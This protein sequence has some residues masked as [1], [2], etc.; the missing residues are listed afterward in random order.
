MEICCGAVVAP[1]SAARVGHDALLPFGSALTDALLGDDATEVRWAAKQIS[2]FGRR[3]TSST[4]GMIGKRAVESIMAKRTDEVDEAVL[5]VCLGLQDD[6]DEAT[7]SNILVFLQQMVAASD[8]PSSDMGLVLLEQCKRF[9]PEAQKG[10]L[11]TLA[12]SLRPETPNLRRLYDL[13][14]RV[15]PQPEWP[16]DVQR[17]VHEAHPTL[18]VSPSEGKGK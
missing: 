12:A 13:M 7:L 16:R 14:C 1:D 5:T 6:L 3:M 8:K 4:R 18:T 2:R 15:R 11:D 10:L 17:R 9:P